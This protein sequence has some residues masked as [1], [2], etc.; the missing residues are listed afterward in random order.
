MKIPKAIH[1]RDAYIDRI[2]PFINKSVVKVMVGHRRVGKSY[3]L[4]QLMEVILAESSDANIIYI[5]KE[6]VAFD[7]INDYK[8]LNDYILS[9]STEGQKNYIFIDEI[10]NI[11]DFHKAIRS[12]VLDENNDIYITGSNS[13]MFSSDLANE[14]GGRYIEFKIYSLSYIEFLSFHNLPNDNKS[15]DRYMRYGGLPYLIHL[16]SNDEVIV[17]YLKSIYS[18][19]VLRD[20][21]QRK[22]IR[23]SIFL[24]QLIRFLADNVGSLFSS[25][26]ISD[27]L[28]SQRVEMSSGAVNDYAVALSQ[29]FVVH[30]V[31][32]YDIVGKRLFERGEKYYFE[33]MGIRNVV[34]GYKPQD[35]AKRLE[36]VVYNHLLYSGYDIKVGAMQSEEIDFVCTKGGETLYVQVTQ[37]LFKEETI[38]RE[39]G[40]LLNIK[41]NYPKIVVS[42]DESYEN[43]YEGVKHIYIRD[44]L[45]SHVE[46]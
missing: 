10:Q 37:E 7:Y 21:V 34:A 43:S 31:G 45:S 9:K 44:F 8:Q 28:K 36:N 3:I 19:I 11:E 39:F 18:T 5:N 41:D 32:R 33:D 24:E 17:E 20:V 22:N 27:Y 2:T 1:R 40:N 23:N 13:Q 4:F 16:P 35:R 42:A 14:M 30:R 29:A 15:L 46:Y 12:L 6:D 25:K 38:A 26:S